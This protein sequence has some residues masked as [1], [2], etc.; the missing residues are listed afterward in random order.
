MKSL[1]RNLSLVLGLSLFMVACSKDDDPVPSPTI[2]LT[3]LGSG[4]NKIGYAGHDLHIDAAIIA[5]GKIASIKL[6]IHGDGADSWAFENLYT[7]SYAGLINAS[8]HEHVDIPE[9]AAPGH[10]HVHFVITDQKGKQ[11]KLEADLE[12]KADPTLP[13][14]TGFEVSTNDD[15]SD[16]HVGVDIQA[17]N[18]IAKLILEIHGNNWEYE[19][20][21]TD[22]AMVGQTAYHFH[23]H[24][25]ISAAPA[26]HYHVHLKIVDQAGK[27]IEFEEH[28]DK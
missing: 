18:K 17:P 14:L 8:F 26:G 10:Y 22:A 13:A 21:Y 20:E 5:P 2:N 7:G 3:E 4:N 15:G 12:I 9:N 6:E 23:K 16:L 27:E 25:N 19:V 24:V 28:F 1:L 11:T